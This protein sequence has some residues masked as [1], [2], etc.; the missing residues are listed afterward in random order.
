[1]AS[2]KL[3]IRFFLA[4]TGLALSA[5]AP[6]AACSSGGTSDTGGGGSTT[7]STT[8]TGGSGGTGG[9]TTTTSSS[10]AGGTGGT[11]GATTTSSSS[12]SS[13]SSTTSS[14]TSSSSSSSGDTW[15]ACH[16]CLK[17]ECATEIAACDDG[18]VGIQACLDAV[19]GNLSV[20]GAPDEGACQVYCQAQH[21][22][23][24]DEHLALINCAQMASACMPP[25]ALAGYDWNQ[26]VDASTKG[27]C[28]PLLDTCT[29]DT[30]CIDYLTCA[31]TCTTT[32]ECK[33]C[34]AT[35]E[36]KAGRDLFEAYWACVER[37]CITEAW[38]PHL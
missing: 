10:S 31:L 29:N 19:C 35:P 15:P 12:S 3:D 38:L 9:A 4:T 8:V 37:D 33:A 36:G 14:S 7:S 27:M 28:G 23:S 34:S 26:C 25:C 20:I 21:F 18:C 6:G 17:T 1:M 30:N 2:S 32:P 16:A 5:L 13:S 24:K 22:S 11:G